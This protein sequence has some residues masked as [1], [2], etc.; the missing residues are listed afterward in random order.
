LLD[1][2]Q[3]RLATESRVATKTIADFERGNRMPYERTLNDLLR[4]FEIGGIIFIEED[5]EAPGVRLRKP[6]AAAE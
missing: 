4:A 1:W 5:G 3:S 2:S 6:L